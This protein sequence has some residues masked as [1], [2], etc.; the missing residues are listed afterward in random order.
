MK[1]R[2]LNDCICEKRA[3]YFMKSPVF[4]KG[5]VLDVEGEFI[6]F[7]GSFYTVSYNGATYDILKRNAELINIGE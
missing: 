3:H 2:I 6:N 7:Y 4:E 5:Q 1:I